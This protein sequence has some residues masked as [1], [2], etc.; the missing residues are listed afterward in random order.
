M[1]KNIKLLPL[2]LLFA[3]SIKSLV[4]SVSIADSAIIFSLAL[5]VA[6]FEFKARDKELQGYKENLQK[7]QTEHE[8]INKRL[9]AVE[10]NISG[11]RLGLGARTMSNVK[12]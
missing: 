8:E 11:L 12:R 4:T 7:F 2:A 3:Y 6:I 1:E 9:E 5:V 10:G